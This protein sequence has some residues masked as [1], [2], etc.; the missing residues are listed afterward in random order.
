L[1][2]RYRFETW[3]ARLALILVTDRPYTRG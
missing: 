1:A 2:T 3:T